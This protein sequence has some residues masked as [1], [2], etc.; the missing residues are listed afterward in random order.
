MGAGTSFSGVTCQFQ[1]FQNIGSA[2]AK[3]IELNFVQ[4]FTFLPDFWN[5]F[6]VDGNFTYVATR[7]DIRTGEE[8]ALPQT[9]PRNFNAE[10]FYDKGPLTL[11]LAAS[12]VSTNLWQV[13]SDA[14]QDLYSQARFRLDFGG[15]YKITDNVE[16][17]VDV[18]NITN[19]KLEFTQ[20]ASPQ[21][22]VQREF[23]DTDFFFG[24][25][26]HL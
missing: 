19:T 3:G 17:Y 23:Y 5:G 4:Q 12:Y 26:A 7:G 13:G 6:G 9:S 11:R 15:S 22:P 16:W 25:R 20:T 1:S 21:Y 18:K 10:V 8:H 14:S 24:V 2:T